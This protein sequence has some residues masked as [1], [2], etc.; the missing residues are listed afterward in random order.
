[1]PKLLAPSE[2]DALKVRFF[3]ISEIDLT[4]TTV[5][6]HPSD[7]FARYQL[8]KLI[9]I[10]RWRKRAVASIPSSYLNLRDHGETIWPATGCSETQKQIAQRLLNASMSRFGFAQNEYSLRIKAVKSRSGQI[11]VFIKLFRFDEQL[12]LRTKQAEIYMN[13]ALLPDGIVSQVFWR[14][15]ESVATCYD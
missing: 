3:V 6:N 1:M 13:A 15:G 10:F 11:V 12:L 2:I 8:F 5:V 9:D 14:I 4:I 7:A